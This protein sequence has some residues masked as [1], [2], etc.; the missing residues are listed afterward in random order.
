MSL[1]AFH[2]LLISVSTLL[3][4]YVAVW[5]WRQPVP[6]GWLTTLALGSL[7]AAVGLPIY[8]VWFVKKTTHVGYL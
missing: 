1:K 4:L 7:V 2:V 6:S 8:G 3:F 5:A